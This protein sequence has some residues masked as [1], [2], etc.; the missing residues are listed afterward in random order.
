MP[1]SPKMKKAK[2]IKLKE[3]MR[4][5]KKGRYGKRKREEK[6][7]YRTTSLRYHPP[8]YSPCYR[9]S[10]MAVEP[11][12]QTLPRVSVPLHVLKAR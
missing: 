11:P 8:Y 12:P 3:N 5:R 7:D 1:P 4:E 2:E 10:S 9:P 6:T